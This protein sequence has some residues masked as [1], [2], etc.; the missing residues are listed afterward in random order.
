[1]KDVKS[2]IKIAPKVFEDLDE[3]YSYITTLSSRNGKTT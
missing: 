2:T 1:M 3:I